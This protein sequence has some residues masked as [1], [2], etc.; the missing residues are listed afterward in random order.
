MSTHNP[1][2][3]APFL[4]ATPRH[5][6]APDSTQ[7][8]ILWIVSELG[9]NTLFTIEILKRVGHSF[10]NPNAI[11]D[12]ISSI[13]YRT[14]STVAF[15]GLF[16]GAILVIQF[17][18]MLEPYDARSF[19][20]GLSASSVVRE[21]G[22]LII[23]FLLAGK[24]GAYTAAEL[25]TMKVTD[26]MDAIRCLGTDPLEYLIVPR[27]VGI[28]LSSL[29]LLMLGLV[30]SVLGAMTV[31]AILCHINNLQFLN[32]VSKFT[33]LG[34]LGAGFFKC[35]LYACIVASVACYQGYNA[36]GGAK[37]VGRAVTL[38]AVQTNLFIVFA[39]YFSGRL[40]EIVEQLY[41]LARD[42]LVGGRF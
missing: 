7:W 34:T 5:P 1:S 16:V 3:P 33:D 18:L 20:G 15:A 32:S 26:Q 10:K 24:I 25:G 4:P 29:M 17:D 14:L 13:C 2:M 35:T 30:V 23:S 22:P 11:L 42:F 39:N 41:L 9:A 31:A 37:G 8:G 19:L 28:V 27:F 36:S 21:I 6:R 40:L 12:Q 38:A